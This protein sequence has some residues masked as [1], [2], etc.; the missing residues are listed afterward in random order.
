MTFTFVTPDRCSINKETITFSN[1]SVSLQ[2]IILIQLPN[3]SL[4]VSKNS[5]QLK[6]SSNEHE[7]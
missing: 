5:T 1:A 4:E 7:Q 2:L 3:T 6:F